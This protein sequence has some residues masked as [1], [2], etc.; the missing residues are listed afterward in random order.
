[1]T[2]VPLGSN[3]RHG[4]G[5]FIPPSW[6]LDS[7]DQFHGAE[8]IAANRGITREEVDGFGL[9]SQQKAAKAWADGRFDREV[10]PIEAHQPDGSTA[11]VGRDQGL[12]ET[13]LE[14]LGG[15]N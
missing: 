12:R 11:V 5:S 6:R 2:R 10:V 13:S 15:L 14:A 1:M 7:P 8:R 4:P 3:V 9:A